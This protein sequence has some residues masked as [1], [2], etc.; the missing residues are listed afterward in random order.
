[1]S[2]T[3]LYASAVL[4][5]LATTGILLVI[6]SLLLFAA[7]TGAAA[8]AAWAA[9]ALVVLAAAHAA[10]FAVLR[11]AG[12]P[13][14]GATAALLTASVVLALLQ[15]ALMYVWFDVGRAGGPLFAAGIQGAAVALVLSTTRGRAIGWAAA[16]LCAVSLLRL[17]VTGGLD[18]AP[19]SSEAG[20]RPPVIAALPYGAA[21]ADA[22]GR[23]PVG[24]EGEAE[25]PPDSSP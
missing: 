4:Y 13:R 6:G 19:S 23:N 15:T 14:P 7:T 8:S 11:G 2:V 24:A 3:V 22:P 18:A 10:L 20:D 16:A 25:P 12:L 17:L 21:V 1:M 9:A 5:S